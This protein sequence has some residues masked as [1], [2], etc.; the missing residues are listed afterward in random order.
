MNKL[1][2]LTAGCAI[3]FS[4]S[5]FDTLAAAS[6]AEGLNACAAAVVTDI[7]SSQGSPL[8]FSMSTDSDMSSVK[9]GQR[10][11]FHLD[12]RSPETDVVVARADCIV[13]RKARVRKVINVPLDAQDADVRSNV[14]L[15]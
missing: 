7:G 13:D 6:R 2:L 14:A 9:L 15:Y 10:E 8:D 11:V 1:K 12:I 3:A 4:V 5:S